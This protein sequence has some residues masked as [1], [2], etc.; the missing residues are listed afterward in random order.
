MHALHGSAAALHMLG[1]FWFYLLLFPSRKLAPRGFWQGRCILGG[2]RSP[3]RGGGGGGWGGAGAS[4]KKSRD[5]K[6]SPS[7]KPAERMCAQKQKQKMLSLRHFSWPRSRIRMQ[8]NCKHGPALLSLELWHRRSRSSCVLPKC[9]H[10]IDDVAMTI[11]TPHCSTPSDSGAPSAQCESQALI[12]SLITLTWGLCSHGSSGQVDGSWN[13]SQLG[14]GLLALLQAGHWVLVCDDAV[15]DA[16]QP[17]A[18]ARHQPNQ[19]AQGFRGHRPTMRFGSTAKVLLR[20]KLK[21][22]RISECGLAS[23][24][25]TNLLISALVRMRPGA[26]IASWAVLAPSQ[27]GKLASTGRLSHMI[28]LRRARRRIILPLIT[29]GRPCQITE[30]LRSRRDRSDYPD[31]ISSHCLREQ[32]I[33]RWDGHSIG[34]STCCQE[35]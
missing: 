11:S 18:D 17:S 30:R 26:L 20:C 12:E 2:L 33:L 28:V 10:E 21:Y 8:Q 4:Q 34:A 31:L 7:L 32:A 35:R 15:A 22:Y 5:I 1:L 23:R 3:P 9:M 16:H 29:T 27:L 24:A 13:C 14:N 6:C 25:S 19:Q